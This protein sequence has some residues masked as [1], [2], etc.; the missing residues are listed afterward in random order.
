MLLAVCAPLGKSWAGA[1]TAPQRVLPVEAFEVGVPGHIVPSLRMKG[2]PPV[3]S[4]ASNLK[5]ELGANFS[6]SASPLAIVGACL[7]WLWLDAAVFS[8]TLCVGYGNP[9]T[10]AFAFLMATASLVTPTASPR[11]SSWSSVWEIA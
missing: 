2:P 6:G 3:S 1:Y 7:F 8:P 5:S 4:S 9:Q 10:Y 11:A